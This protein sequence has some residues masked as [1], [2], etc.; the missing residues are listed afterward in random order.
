MVRTDATDGG[1]HL[2]DNGSGDAPIIHYGPVEAYPIAKAL[3]DFLPSRESAI[4]DPY[5]FMT[6]SSVSL[7]LSVIRTWRACSAAS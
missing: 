1:L 5:C 3:Y 7:P 6:R 4:R 2:R